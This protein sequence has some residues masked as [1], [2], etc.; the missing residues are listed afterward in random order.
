KMRS[1]RPLPHLDD[2]IVGA[3]NGWMIWAFA[4]A[5]RSLGEPRYIEAA[6]KAL[7]FA[8]DHLWRSGK[9]ARFWRDGEARGAGTSEDYASLVHA[10]LEVQQAAGG[11]RWSKWALDL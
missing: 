2:K 7:T 3:W 11:E 10:C 8:F 5:G 1:A 9:L 6:E 4:L